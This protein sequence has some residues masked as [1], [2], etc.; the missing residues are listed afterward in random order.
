MT[1]MLVLLVLITFKKIRTRK[2]RG[3]NEIVLSRIQETQENANS[4]SLQELQSSYISLITHI[5]VIKKDTI[6]RR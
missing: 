3:R 2:I 5:S 4:V 1:L 6:K